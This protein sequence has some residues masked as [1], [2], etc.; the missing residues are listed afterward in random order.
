MPVVSCQTSERLV[1][2]VAKVSFNKCPFLGESH[3]TISR[4]KIL[5]PPNIFINTRNHLHS[6]TEYLSLQT[7]CIW[8]LFFGFVCFFNLFIIFFNFVCLLLHFCFYSVWKHYNIYVL[9]CIYNTNYMFHGPYIPPELKRKRK[10]RGCRGIK[11]VKLVKYHIHVL[12]LNYIV[13]V[14]FDP[15]CR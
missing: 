4:I 6:K 7:W 12:S 11:S 15:Y 3:A 5:V 1:A 9:N 8:R 2:T 14:A 10:K 13:Y